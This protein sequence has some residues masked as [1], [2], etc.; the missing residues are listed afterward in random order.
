MPNV[1]VSAETMDRLERM[2]KYMLEQSETMMGM[3]LEPSF[4]AIVAEL[5]KKF[6]E[7]EGVE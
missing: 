5:C 4:G 6:C 3:P 7:E 2:Q 1:Y